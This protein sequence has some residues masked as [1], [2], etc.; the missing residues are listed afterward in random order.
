MPMTITEY[1]ENRRLTTKE[2]VK[3][4]LGITVATYDDLINTFIDQVTDDFLNFT[5]RIFE[6]QTYQESVPG[7]GS[8]YLQLHNYPIREPSEILLQSTPIVDAVVDDADAGQLYRANGWVWTAWTGWNVERVISTHNLPL[9]IVTYQGGYLVPDDN[10]VDS[11]TIS[12]DDSDDSFNDSAGLFPNVGAGDRITMS[13]FT[14]ATNNGTFTVVSRTALKIVVDGTLTTEVAGANRSIAFRNLPRDLEKLCIDQV[15]TYYNSRED[16][17]RVESTKV[18]DLAIKFSKDAA[19]GHL[20]PQVQ[21]G[22][23]RYRR[24]V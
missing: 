2:A 6:R 9:F 19:T 5:D 12:V 23:V 8:P 22:L 11:D 21:S 4:E 15:K 18:G 14:A 16:D 10:I 7:D 1:A 3:D 13:D 17:L 24:A 20:T